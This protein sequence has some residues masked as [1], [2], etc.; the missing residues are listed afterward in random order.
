MF[1]VNTAAPE[2]GREEKSIARSR[3]DF[4]MPD[5]TPAARYP[6]GAVIPPLIVRQ[7]PLLDL[8][9]LDLSDFRLMCR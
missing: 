3:P 6:C 1:R 9:L 8:R 5:A 4:L 7:P 2:A